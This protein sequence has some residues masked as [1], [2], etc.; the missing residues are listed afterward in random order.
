MQKDNFL[1]GAA[2]LGFAGLIIKVMGAF[3]RIPLGYIIGSEGLGYYQVGYPIYAFLLSFSAAGFPTAISKLV[4]EKRAQGNHKGA[5]QVFK[6]S[7]LLLLIIGSI[8]SVGLLVGA[9]YFVNN[10]VESPNAYYAVLALAPALFFVSLLAAFRGYFQGM[11]NMIPTAISQIVE[12]FGRVIIGLALAVIL[13]K[14]SVELAAASASFGA[15][16]GGLIGLL[17][18]IWAFYNNKRKQNLNPEF[19]L[20]GE[21][22]T[23]KGVIKDLF[24][25]SI[26]ITIGASVLPIITMVDSLIVL[27]RLQEIGFTYPEANKLFGQLTG[28]AVTL[29]NMPQVLT[30]ALATSIVPVVAESVARGDMEAV[31]KDALSAFRISLLVGL[32]AAVGLAV[33]STPIMQLL[34]PKEPAS[35]GDILLFLS[36]AVLFLTQVQTLT[37]ILQGLGKPVIPVRNLMIGAGVKLVTTYVLTG[38]PALNVKGAALGTVA[39]YLVASVL[40]FIAVK[41][42]TQTEFNLYR[43]FIKPIISV[44]TMAIVVK[45]GYML[46]IPVV[47]SKLSTVL[48]IF[49]GAVVYG[50]MLLVTKTLTAEDFELLPGGI[51]LSRLLQ[52]VGML[53]N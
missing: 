18:M 38:I 26:P 17:F 24:K 39:A 4:S 53:R 3:F 19:S 51:R 45:L 52:K 50:I 6:V 5:Y 12:Q 44:L 42:H 29:I 16:I 40:N 22:D 37:G 23:L 36:L 46:F 41:K 10:I 49:C 28:M 47:G 33:L 20:E 9:R 34:F 35:V 13:M 48:S 21:E 25:I 32:P 30:V 14:R 31:R 27:R 11:K 8:S 1:K 15:T 43:V 7:F 2:I